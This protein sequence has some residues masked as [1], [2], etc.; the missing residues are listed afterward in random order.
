MADPVSNAPPRRSRFLRAVLWLGLAVS[1]AR[2]GALWY[3]FA[4]VRKYELPDEVSLPQWLWYPEALL[5]PPS[6]AWTVGWAAAFSAALLVGSFT[7]ALVLA[8][9]GRMGSAFGPNSKS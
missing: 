3:A 9:I 6:F 8:A 1:L 5:L 7:I 2:I 4:L